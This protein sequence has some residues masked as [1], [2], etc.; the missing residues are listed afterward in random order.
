[1]NYFLFSIL[2]VEGVRSGLG[3]GQ[4]WEE[5]G[6]VARI[7]CTTEQEKNSWVAAINAEVRQLRTMAKTLENS[8]LFSYY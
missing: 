3:A 1:M 5:G 4:G 7:T 8:F 6:A 2:K